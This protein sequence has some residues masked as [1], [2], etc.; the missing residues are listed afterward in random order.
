MYI[1]GYSTYILGQ[2]VWYIDASGYT[3]DIHFVT[4]G[5]TCYIHGY[6]VTACFLSRFALIGA[7]RCSSAKHQRLPLHLWPAQY[8]TYIP[9]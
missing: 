4:V 5:Y 1:H 8:T 2:Y 7:L 3:M 6:T 9:P